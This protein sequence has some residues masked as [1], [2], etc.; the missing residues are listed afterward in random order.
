MKK[1]YLIIL[2]FCLVSFAN[3]QE[4]RSSDN[5]L[6]AMAQIKVIKFYPNPATTV[7]NFELIKPNQKNITLQVYNFVGKKLFEKNNIN[8]KTTLPLNEFY[9]GVYIY[10]LRDNY[11]RIVESGKFQVVK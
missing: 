8:Q 10:Q 9:R 5:S 1:L 7:I 4:V 11:G 6:S 2:F 3:A